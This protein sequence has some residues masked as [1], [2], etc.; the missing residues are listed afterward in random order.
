MVVLGVI[1][2][3]K[4]EIRRENEQKSLVISSLKKL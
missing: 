4:N 2:S 3:I 1:L